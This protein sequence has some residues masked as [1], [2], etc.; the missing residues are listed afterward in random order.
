VA[1]YLVWQRRIRDLFRMAWLPIGVAVLVSAPWSLLIYRR[2][3]DFWPFFFWNEHVR[4]FLS[5]DAQHGK[6]FWYFLLFAPAMFMPWA[7]VAP[8]AVR[9]IRGEAGGRDP[10]GRLL[11]LSL[12][13]FV[14]PFLFFSISKGKLLT[15]I[16]PCFPP[17]AILL[18]FGLSHVLEKGRSRAFQWGLLATGVLYGL[19]L[20]ALVSVQWF[21]YQGMR[22]YDNPWAVI[23]L[24]GSLVVFVTL[25]FLAF[26]SGTGWKK[27]PLLGLAPV[28]LFFVIPSALP[29]RVIEAQCPGFLLG[30]HRGDVGPDT[31]TISDE[32][33]T[34]AAC[35][36]FRR[37]NVYVLGKTGELGYGLRCKDAVG[38][39]LDVESAIR[40]ISRYPDKTVLVMRSRHLPDWE[41]CLPE[42]VQQDDDGTDGFAF[43]RF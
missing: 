1:P 30:R 28:L 8:A 23:P 43:L 10:R 25:V 33:T 39:V 3:P 2:E 11:R 14:L 7:F 31:V 6:P 20:L 34:A 16:L 12:C 5:A 29:H 35:W 42:P 38:R 37:S 24:T 13:W 22:P 15:Y 40:M 4:R 32:D 36:Y 26:R 41:D 19:I 27:I 9:G 17:F 18:S 21:G